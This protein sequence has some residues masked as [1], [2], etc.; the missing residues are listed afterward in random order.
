SGASATSCRRARCASAPHSTSS[1]ASLS[2]PQR[3]QRTKDTEMKR[4]S[5][6]WVVACA[7]ATI[8]IA[9]MLADNSFT[10]AL[11]GDSL[12]TMKL[13]VHTDP[14]FLKMIDLIRGA[15][16]AFT[17]LEMLL[18]DYEPYPSTESGGTYMRADPELAK[19]LVWA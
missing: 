16:A 18:H 8:A 12:L 9:P 2:R 17:N 6:R 13:S 10:L 5:L 11:T 14:P 19:E 3:T 15:D 1:A 7:L 4:I